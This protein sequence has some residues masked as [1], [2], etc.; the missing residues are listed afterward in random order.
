VKAADA[1][2]VE[3]HVADLADKHAAAV[4]SA[5]ALAMAVAA[6]VTERYTSHPSSQ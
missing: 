6:D 5:A 4:G 3:K 1:E 2:L